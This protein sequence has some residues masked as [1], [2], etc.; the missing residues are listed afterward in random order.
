MN[1]TDDND[2]YHKNIYKWLNIITKQFILT[3][4]QII[5]T[6]V[7]FGYSVWEDS[8]SPNHVFLKTVVV[9]FAYPFRDFVVCFIGFTVYL[10]FASQGTLYS[11]I[12]RV[13]HISCLKCYS[14]IIGEDVDQKCNDDRIQINTYQLVIDDK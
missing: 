11:R 9:T 5:M 6:Q 3:L 10:A 7:V 13:C 4:S 14:R 8:M 1:A 12:C 2:V